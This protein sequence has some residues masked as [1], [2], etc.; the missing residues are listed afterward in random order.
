MRGFSDGLW[1]EMD[2]AW[3]DFGEECGGKSDLKSVFMR[4]PNSGEGSISTGVRE[5]TFAYGFYG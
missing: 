5:M 3:S 2:G 4:R 1:G